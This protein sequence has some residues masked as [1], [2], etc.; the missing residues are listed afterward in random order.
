MSPTNCRN[1]NPFDS[2]QTLHWDGRSSAKVGRGEPLADVPSLPYTHDVAPEMIDY[3]VHAR[4]SRR[5]N[6]RVSGPPASSEHAVVTVGSW[7]PAVVRGRARRD[8]QTVALRRVRPRVR[9]PGNVGGDDA[10]LFGGADFIYVARNGRWGAPL[11]TQE[12]WWCTD[13]TWLR[14]PRAIAGTQCYPDREST[15]TEYKAGARKATNARY[16]AHV[17]A[18]TV[19]DWQVAATDR[20]ATQAVSAALYDDRNEGL[21]AKAHDCFGKDDPDYGQYLGGAPRGCLAESYDGSYTPPS[22]RS[23]YALQMYP[24]K[25]WGRWQVRGIHYIADS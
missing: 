1:R 15:P 16:A 19:N 21:M 18:A 8:S 7:W 10:C 25:K 22:Y 5:K 17:V 3:G 24:V 20:Y 6:R 23:I 13:L 4:E 14:V 2:A 12:L 9:G 11:G